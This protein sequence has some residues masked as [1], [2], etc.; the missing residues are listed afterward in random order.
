M[1]VDE[2]IDIFW[3]DAERSTFRF[4][5]IDHRREDNQVSRG[6]YRRYGDTYADGAY[7]VDYD[8]EAWLYPESRCSVTA[9][10]LARVTPQQWFIIFGN[11]WQEAESDEKTRTHGLPA[12]IHLLES[13]LVKLG[14][15]AR[16]FVNE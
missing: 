4:E 6:L 14:F 9:S 8:E 5:T 3:Y 11:A 13:V 1:N 7:P 15:T 10:G 16:S 12:E 2:L